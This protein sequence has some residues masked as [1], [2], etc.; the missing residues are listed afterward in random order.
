MSASPARVR[1]AD[2]APA[3][4]LAVA[5]WEQIER[6][7]PALAVT[8]RRY[9]GQAATFLA[10]RS[11]AAADGALRQLARWL[12]ASTG[13]E[14]AAGIRRDDIEDFK[15]WLSEQDGTNGTLSANTFGQRLR[16]LRVFFER[17]IEW[18]WPDAPPRNPVIGGDIPPRPDP[19]PRFLDDRDAARLMAAARACAD[20][21]DRLVIELL[22]RT[23]MRA[24]E[25]AD[26]EADAVVLIGAAHWLRIPL[27]KLRNDRYV[28][29]HP[30]L[31]TLL[32]A[33]HRQP[34]PHPRL[35]P[36]RRR[37]PR[38]PEPLPDRPYRRPRRPQLRRQRPPPPAAPHPGHPGH[39]PGHA[40]GGDRRPPRPPDH[41][42]DPDLRPHR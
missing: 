11:V 15:V 5:E 21:R 8:M 38:P 34:G 41:G 20:P 35:P 1:G 29:L 30:E 32:A 17:I 6:A 2:R 42:N 16:M 31:V 27:G 33:D 14:S 39:Q 37:P 12:L 26:L 18:D 28:P 40:A 23:G 9:L 3:G 4:T 7:A 13:I 24:G 36:P 22:A 19:L 10:P 25:L